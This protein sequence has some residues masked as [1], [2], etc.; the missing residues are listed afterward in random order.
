MFSAP[1]EFRSRSNEVI[2]ARC[3]ANLLSRG[4]RPRLCASDPQSCPDTRGKKSEG[5]DSPN[6]LGGEWS[7]VQAHSLQPPHPR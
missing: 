1:G 4:A 2:L 7:A 5:Y 6:K 3:G